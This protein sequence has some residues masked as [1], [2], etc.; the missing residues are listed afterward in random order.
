MLGQGQ[1]AQQRQAEAC[2]ESLPPPPNRV[3][4]LTSSKPWELRCI[5]EVLGNSSKARGI[6]G[7]GFLDV[8]SNTH[9]IE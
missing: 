4:A 2:L 7:R 9:A 1:E 5:S 6:L 8:I 3:L